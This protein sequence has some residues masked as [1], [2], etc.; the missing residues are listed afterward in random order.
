MKKLARALNINRGWAVGLLESLW[1]WT[2]KF[3]PQGDIG[4]HE[5]IDIAEGCFWDRDPEELIEALV[6]TGWVDQCPHSRLVIHDWHDHADEAVTKRLSRNGLQFLT[7]LDTVSTSS[8]H[9]VGAVGTGTG[10]GTGSGRAVE[11]FKEAMEK[12]PVQL[13]EQVKQDFAEMVFE[14]WLGQGRKN[15]N[16]IL[17]EFASY[18]RKRWFSEGE[19]WRNNCHS[20]QLKK[21]ANNSKSGGKVV[22]RNAGTANAKR[23]G[24]YDGLGQVP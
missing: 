5:D 21:H 18:L 11:T 22:D 17:V 19:Q 16:G 7:C 3:A 20:E 14:G 13:Q 12:V 9:V 2:S 4:K 6:K 24:Q 8:E 15:G 23:T 10:S 1:H